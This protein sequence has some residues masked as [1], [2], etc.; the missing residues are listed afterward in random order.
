VRQIRRD[1]SKA[2][3][4]SIGYHRRSLGETAMSRLKGAFGDRLKNRSPPTKPPRPRYAARSSTR[5]SRSECRCRC[6]VSQQR[7]S[8]R[9]FVEESWAYLGVFERGL[10]VRDLDALRVS[11]Y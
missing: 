2:W 9:Q 6:G 5:S 10:P 8:K 3:K 1:G 7:Q 11:G 4:E